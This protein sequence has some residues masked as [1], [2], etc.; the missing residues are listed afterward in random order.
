MA[1]AEAARDSMIDMS[2]KTTDSILVVFFVSG[3]CGLIYESVWAHYVKLMLGHAA[4]AQTL[5]LVVFIGGLALGSWLC[6]RVAER[7]R[8][9]LRLYALV[10][11][12]IGLMAL[13]F[14]AVFVSAVD[15]GYASLLPATCEQASTFCAGQWMLSAVLLAP[16]SILLGMT[17]PLMSSAVVRLADSQP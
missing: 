10:E 14:H 2:R 17:F 6:A 13:A 4:Y 1:A 8:N 5:V 12:A 16:Q 9:P 15:W 7:I 3:F 11:A